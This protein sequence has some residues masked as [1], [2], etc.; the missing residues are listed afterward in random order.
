MLTYVQVAIALD[1]YWSVTDISYSQR[2]TPRRICIMLA[3]V[4]V[5]S[6]A[7]SVAPIFGWKDEEFYTRINKY[8]DCLISQDPWYQLFAASTAFYLPLFAII[9]IYWRVF[10]VRLLPCCSLR[11]A[12]CRVCE[13]RR[14]SDASSASATGRR[15]SWPT[16]LAGRCRRRRPISLRA[17][18][19]RC[20]R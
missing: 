19:A 6:A 4:W 17:I 8:N 10:K 11:G 18:P 2:R 7:L 20:P 15:R 5:V 9:F 14:R 1:R 12:M 13:C 16:T 3:V